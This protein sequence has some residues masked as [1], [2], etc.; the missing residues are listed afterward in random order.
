MD[1]VSVLVFGITDSLEN[2]GRQKRIGD[3]GE[4]FMSIH[5]LSPL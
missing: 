4:K 5:F 2:G 3:S 1:L